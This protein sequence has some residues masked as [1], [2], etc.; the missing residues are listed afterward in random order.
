MY[1]GWQGFFLLAILGV[2]FG[3]GYFLASS[4]LG[5]PDVD[6]A[7]KPVMETGEERDLIS[8]DTQVIYEEVYT[9]CG[10]VIISEFPERDILNGKTVDEIK[11]IYKGGYEIKTDDEALI[12]RH[13]V[14]AYC[15]SEY[16]K[17]RLK[18]Y[19]GY[20]AIYKGPLEE[21]VLE[22]VTN[23]KIR[24][25]PREEQIK[26]K[27]GDYEFRDEMALKDALENFDEYI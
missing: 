24:N 22:K 12:I 8:E 13:R 2:F 4:L 10:H 15:P 18:E 11:G 19:K 5:F 14:D 1:K 7:R 17:R 3:I 6:K 9:K 16:E 20:V 21:E 26:I 23:I 27:R 25:L